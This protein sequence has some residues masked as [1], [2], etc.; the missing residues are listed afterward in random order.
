MDSVFFIFPTCPILSKVQ[1]RKKAPEVFNVWRQNQT[2]KGIK[3]ILENWTI[4]EILRI[5]QQQKKKIPPKD[6]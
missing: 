3:N 2:L 6:S 5:K 4:K 1:V